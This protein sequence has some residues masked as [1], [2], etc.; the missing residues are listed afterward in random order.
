[1]SADFP[2]S[3][4]IPTRDG[5]CHSFTFKPTGP[6]PWPAVLLYM[7]A[8]AIRPAM[9]ELG[10][11]MA[12]LGCCVLIPDLFYRSG[13]YDAMNPHDIFATPNGF[14][15]IKEKFMVHASMANI[16]S[17]TTAFLDFLAHDT[18]VRS[19]PVGT[20]GYC[21][22]ARF[23]LAAAGTWPDRIGVCA[24]FHG[25]NLA[26]DDVD[27]PH[28]LAAKMKARAF[29]AG[30]TDDSGFPDAMKDRLAATLR[31]AG[32]DHVVETW[33]ARHGWTFHD[34]PVYDEACFEHHLD[35]LA[36]LFHDVLGA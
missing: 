30:A 4:M 17:D 11:R 2:A 9:M 6:G 24:A 23:A 26:T 19:G 28:H 20:V 34:T 25:S 27:S 29:I 32:V 22:G 33:P 15:A 13:P 35:V 18:D 16:L 8:F 12:D 5:I 1:M 14:M 31:G 21:M 3:T 36:E 10:Q 7:D